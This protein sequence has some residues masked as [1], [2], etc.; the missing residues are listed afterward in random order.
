ML[1]HLV[2]IDLV[3]GLMGRAGLAVALPLKAACQLRPSCSLDTWDRLLPEP[4][5]IV[6]IRSLI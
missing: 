4:L 1:A 3:F 5:L 2:G 6:S